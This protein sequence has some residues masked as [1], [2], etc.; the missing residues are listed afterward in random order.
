MP[1]RLSASGPRL[2]RLLVVRQRIGIGLGA[3]HFQR[4]RVGIVGQ[5]DA[6]LIGGIG[7]RH[8]LRA[9]AERHH[10]R[11]RP[12]DQR[13]GLRKER[14]AEAAL[15]DRRGIVVVELLRDVARQLHVLLLVFADRHMRCAID[16]DVGRHQVWIGVKSDR[17]ILAVLAG[18]LL[19]LGHAIEPAQPRHAVEHPGELGVLGNLALVE[20]DVL[21]RIDAA[22]DERRG[23]LADR[24][25]QLVRLLPHRDGVQVDHAID[26]VVRVLQLDEPDDGAEVVAEM[27]V[28]GRLHPG[29]HLFLERLDGWR[30]HVEI[31]FACGHIPQRPG[32]CKRTATMPLDVAAAVR[33]TRFIPPRFRGGWPSGG[34][35]RARS[36]GDCRTLRQS[37]PTRPLADARVHPPPAGE[38]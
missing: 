9:V 2:Q 21:L 22:G 8:F 30:V 38:G 11:R 5:V 1:T 4:D 12:L 25:G 35:S 17:G 24:L 32:R 10:P 29:E 14:L 6:R 27:Q 36:G 13:L 15:A 23:H 37:S 18:L 28:A 33:Q 19:E 34:D 16:Q 7:L 26:A 31:P 20:H 3:A